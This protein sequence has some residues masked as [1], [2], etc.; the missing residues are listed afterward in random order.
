M[1]PKIFI[2][3]R[4]ADSQ[5][6]TDRLFEH[7]EKHFGPEN[8][9]QDVGDSGKIPLGV[10]FVDYLAEQV[11]ACDV[12]LVV[13][14][15]QWLRILKERL[16]RDD[17]F[18]RIEVES[19]LEQGKI[20]IPVLK[21][22][23]PMPAGADLPASIRKVARINASRV[24]PN[25]DFARDCETLAEGVRR[26]FGMVNSRSGVSSTQTP[27]DAALQRAEGFGGKRNRDWQPF[28][29][30]FADLPIPDMPFCL[31][32]AGSFQMGSDDGISNEQPVHEQRIAQP[33]WIAQ[34]PVTNAQ[35]LQAVRAGAVKEP[36][37]KSALKW[38]KDAALADAPLVGVDWFMARDFAAWMGCR[39]P[40]EAEWEYAARGVES[41][42]YPWGSNWE[43][44]ERVIWDK[45]SGG[46]PNLGTSK[47]EGASWVDARHLIGNVWEWTGS[48]YQPYPY[49]EDDGRRGSGGRVRG[50]LVARMRVCCFAAA[51]ITGDFVSPA[52]LTR[53]IALILPAAL[54]FWGGTFRGASLASVTSGE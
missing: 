43:D 17:D 44:G 25:P 52:A 35:W 53:Y 6:F 9:F 18:V 22:A 40:T 51:R 30:T 48:R 23:T 46:R 14:G 33:Y 32:P 50:R 37:D 47:P 28:V 20:I 13:I 8:V 21:S 42:R 41:W 10:D 27:L 31:V 15:E 26:V 3:Y 4:R 5:D 34:Y 29:T 45:T 1:T 24:R 36:K 54:T 19:A 11:R 49:T 39:L 16:D 2:S 38:Y 12:V 7:M